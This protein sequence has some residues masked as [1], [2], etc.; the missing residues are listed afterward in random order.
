MNVE[1]QILDNEKK[2][3]DAIKK[4]GIN[5]LEELLHDDLLFVI[6]NGQVIT[7]TIDL[8]N[9][10]SGKIFISD[11]S[12]DQPTV[13]LIDDVAVS[14]MIVEIKGTYANH[15]IDGKF[16]YMRIWKLFGSQWQVIGGS[17]TQL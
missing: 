15:P 6:P 9:Y 11:I 8:D 16:R 14:T 4:N 7:K 1:R 5:V 3:L 17:G 10:R 13:K 12:S 2:L